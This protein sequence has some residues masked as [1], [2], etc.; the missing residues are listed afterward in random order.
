MAVITK[1]L[2]SDEEL[3]A[4]YEKARLLS[5]SAESSRAG[6][7][8]RRANPYSDDEDEHSHGGGGDGD[9]EDNDD[10]DDEGSTDNERRAQSRA[11]ERR[12]GQ[13]PPSRFKRAALLLFVAVLLW[14]AIRMRGDLLAAKKKPQI[15]YA[16]RYSKEHK[17]RP[18]ASPI[19]TETLKDGRIRL[20]GANPPP[21]PTPTPVVKKKTKTKKRTG[22]KKAVK[23]GKK[24]AG[25][26]AGSGK[27]P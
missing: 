7:P 5:S 21:T 11:F 4:T 1:E 8:V 15:I 19:I 22:K 26:K 2:D 12:Y 16:S 24:K 6:T 13:R 3:D 20:R 18:A 14:L 23:G 25:S 9:D 17:Y 27:R 10:D